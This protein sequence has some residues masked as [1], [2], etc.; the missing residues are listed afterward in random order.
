MSVDVAELEGQRAALTAHCYRM[1][2]SMPTTHVVFEPLE[3]VEKL[4]ASVPP[5]KFNLVRYHGLL[6]PA[7]RW[8]RHVV[9]QARVGTAAD[10]PRHSRCGA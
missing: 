3:L 10:S 7:A 5:P 4:A 6:A 1:L 2:G 8:R 9:P